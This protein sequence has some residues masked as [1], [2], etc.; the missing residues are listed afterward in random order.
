MYKVFIDRAL[1]ESLYIYIYY[2]FISINY[3]MQEKVFVNNN[4]RVYYI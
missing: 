4:K 2:T 1:F 3:Y